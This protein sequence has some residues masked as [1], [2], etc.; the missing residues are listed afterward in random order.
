MTQKEIDKFLTNTKVYVNGKSK[1][2]Q[3]KLFSLGYKWSYGGTCVSYTESPFLF[4]NKDMSLSW[5]NDM[6]YF[7]NHENREISA[8]QILSLKL[9]EPKYR[10]F[11]NA[12]ECWAEMLKHQ[13]FGWI[14]EKATQSMSLVSGVSPLT[15]N[16]KLDFLDI[17]VYSMYSIVTFADGAPFGIKED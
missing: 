16:I 6:E 12:E 5:N 1:E 10:P 3:E 14:K 15:D 8:E 9:T 13:P 17:A 7:S 2:I 4:I 11:K